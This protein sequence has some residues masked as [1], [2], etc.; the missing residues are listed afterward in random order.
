MG[1]AHKTMTVND[2]YDEVAYDDDFA[3]NDLGNKY[4]DE[5]TIERLLEDALK[6]I[7]VFIMLHFVWLRFASIFDNFVTYVG[8]QNRSKIDQKL[9]FK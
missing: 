7:A 1:P 5:P 6:M 8:S 3:C 4:L 9:M 2:P